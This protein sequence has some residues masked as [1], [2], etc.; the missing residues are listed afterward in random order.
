VEKKTPEWIC[1][2]W[3][4]GRSGVEKNVQKALKKT[5][6]KHSKPFGSVLELK[7][8]FCSG[9]NR[10]VVFFSWIW[11]NWSIL[12]LV[13]SVEVSTIKRIQV[14]IIIYI[15]H[16]IS[17][18]SLISSIPLFSYIRFSYSIQFSYGEIGFWEPPAAPLAPLPKTCARS[19]WK[20]LGSTKQFM[21]ISRFIGDLC[22]HL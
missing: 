9:N 18:Y 17:E 13:C 1:R 14:Y 2:S 11:Q 15:Y 16:Y 22:R 8:T 5:L 21:G 19:T 4:F 12:A 7:K 20:M 3:H 6:K 10:S